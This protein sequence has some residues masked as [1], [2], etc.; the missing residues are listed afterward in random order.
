MKLLNIPS[1][2]IPCEC[3]TAYHIRNEASFPVNGSV[4]LATVHR[5]DSASSD[6]LWLTED[7][8]ILGPS[9]DVLAGCPLELD[10]KQD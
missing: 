7:G 10:V 6:C 1:G 8:Y 4:I 9:L 2:R 3:K 5:Q